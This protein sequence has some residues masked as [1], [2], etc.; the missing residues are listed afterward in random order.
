MRKGRQEEAEGFV[1][2]GVMVRGA[3]FKGRYAASNEKRRE[4]ESKL[5]ATMLL[6][7]YVSRPLEKGRA[8]RRIEMR[9][10]RIISDSPKHADVCE[11]FCL[12]PLVLVVPLARHSILRYR[13]PLLQG[14]TP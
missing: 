3:R 12:I 14:A 7:P 13:A 4:F 2:K 1:A 10:R 6:W 5:K 8:K 9:R 11:G